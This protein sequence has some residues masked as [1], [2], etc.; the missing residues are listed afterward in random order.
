MGRLRRGLRILPTVDGRSLKHGGLEGR[1]GRG[2]IH[3][4][5][6]KKSVNKTKYNLKCKKVQERELERWLSG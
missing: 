3:I 6:N 1:E 2:G 5:G 4:S